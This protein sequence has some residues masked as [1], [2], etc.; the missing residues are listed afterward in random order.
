MSALED[1]LAE[2]ELDSRQ[3]DALLL[4]LRPLAQCSA[5][6]PAPSGQLARL[7]AAVPAPRTSSS[8]P[9]LARVAA[10]A[11]ALSL[12]GVGATGLAAA[13]NNLPAPLQQRISDLSVRFLPFHVPA[14]LP[15]RTPP[16]NDAPLSGAEP[17]L[18][19]TL[20]ITPLHP[21]SPVESTLPTEPGGTDFAVGSLTTQG[22]RAVEPHH[23]ESHH[24]GKHH[25][26]GDAGT[27]GPLVSSPS[28]ST[29]PGN[30]TDTSSTS[31][32]GATGTP[33][34]QPAALTATP[35]APGQPRAP[36]SGSAGSHGPSSLAAAADPSG[37]PGAPA[38][39]HTS[40]SSGQ[41][42]TPP[43]GNV[44]GGSGSHPAHGPD[45]EKPRPNCDTGSAGAPGRDGGSSRR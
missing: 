33:T 16:A 43:W 30:T 36:R 13:A 18:G 12:A 14:P 6:V 27:P 5:K 1:M 17:R 39:P 37:S 40:Q 25:L 4:V 44:T 41:P 29:S 24:A 2:S 8:R 19:H 9:R 31:S 38:D 22:N 15:A 45:G 11:L 32:P 20:A 26:A 28:A 7:F 21:T 42:P 35:T 3:R 10:G 34:S 23:S